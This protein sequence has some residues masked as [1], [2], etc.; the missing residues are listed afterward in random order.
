MTERIS[1][2]KTQRALHA[3]KRG[4]Q[5]V[6]AGVS[7]VFQRDDLAEARSELTQRVGFWKSARSLADLQHAKTG[8]LQIHIRR[9][10]LIDNCAIQQLKVRSKKPA[11]VAERRNTGAGR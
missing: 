5:R 6:I 8:R 1:D 11:A 4:L 7:A 9:I 3:A 2:A 10:A